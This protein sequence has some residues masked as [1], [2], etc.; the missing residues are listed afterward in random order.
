MRTT[1]ILSL[2]AIALAGCGGPDEG[3]TQTEDSDTADY[4]GD[5]DD[6]DT[7][8]IR[9]DDGEDLVINTGSA[10]SVNLPDGYSIYPGASVVNTTS[11]NQSDGQGMLMILQ[12]D[13]SPE[14]MVTFYRQQAENAG[15]EI[16]TEVNA[17]GTMMVAGESE[18]GHT[19][20]FSASPSGEGTQGQL[21]V[22]Q[23]LN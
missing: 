1:I 16:G 21:V 8:I 11:M 14:S 9:G 17:N 7:V 22:G 12:S 6:G 3:S 4:Q 20:S 2:A 5:G 19:F 13:A 18:E 23:G 15:I 10:A